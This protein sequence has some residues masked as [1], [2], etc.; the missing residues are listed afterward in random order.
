MSSDIIVIEG[1]WSNE[2]YPSSR[3][4]TSSGMTYRLPATL[5]YDA[6]IRARIAGRAI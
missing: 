6:A 1:I 3:I 4:F 5:D 2:H